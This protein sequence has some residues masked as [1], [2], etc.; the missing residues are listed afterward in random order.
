MPRRASAARNPGSALHSSPLPYHSSAVSDGWAPGTGTFAVTVPVSSDTVTIQVSRSGW[1]Y[2]TTTAARGSGAP[3]QPRTTSFGGSARATYASRVSGPTAA[4]AAC[5]AAPASAT[6]SGASG[7]RAAVFF[8]SERSG[9]TVT[10]NT[11]THAR[12]IP[13]GGVSRRKRDP[14]QR[15]PRH[16]GSPDNAGLRPTIRPKRRGADALLLAQW[17]HRHRLVAE[18]AERVPVPGRLRLVDRCAAVRAV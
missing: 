8:S 11:P 6:V 9:A 15:A 2:T 18:F 7:W 12:L 14:R 1:E 3:S 5:A 13:G 10:A 16:V 17:R 4:S